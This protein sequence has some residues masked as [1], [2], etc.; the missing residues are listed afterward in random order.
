MADK[1]LPSTNVGKRGEG[2]ND[3]RSSTILDTSVAQHGHVVTV[4]PR[5]AVRHGY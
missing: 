3:S 5:L 1:E 2:I 4:S